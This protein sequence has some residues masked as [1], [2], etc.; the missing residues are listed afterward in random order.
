MKLIKVYMADEWPADV[1]SPTGWPGFIAVS[2]VLRFPELVK[3]GNMVLPLW[4][5]ET[6]RK[7]SEM[8]L[9]MNMENPD[10]PY[11]ILTMSE[12]V[13]MRLRRLIVQTNAGCVVPGFEL[14]PDQVELYFWVNEEWVMMTIPET[15]I[16][17][18]PEPYDSYWMARAN[19]SGT[20]IEAQLARSRMKREKAKAQKE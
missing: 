10:F 14:L 2:E 6:M 18:P 5:G 15:G 17:N 19:E 3:K 11:A 12:A 13:V 16:L 8:V 9:R 1:Q 7:V 20:I 4:D